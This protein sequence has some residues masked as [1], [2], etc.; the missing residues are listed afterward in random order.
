MKKFVLI[1]TLFFLFIADS[2]AAYLCPDGSYVNEGPC[3]LCPN[4][5]YIGSGDLCQLVLDETYKGPNNLN[6]HNQIAEMGQ[7]ENLAYRGRLPY[8]GPT[9][10]SNNANDVFKAGIEAQIQQQL[11]QQQLQQQYQQ[12]QQQREANP[13]I[14]VAYNEYLRQGDHKAFAYSNDG[15]AGWCV[16]QTGQKK[17]KDCALI[18]CEQYR[19]SGQTAPCY[20]WAFDET[21]LGRQ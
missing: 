17:A 12:Q 2:F 9:H 8:S 4:G 3:T 1:N 15:F 5:S 19:Q 21:V 14:T 18:N 20:I 10:S 11:Y 13:R 7:A 6:I 16:M